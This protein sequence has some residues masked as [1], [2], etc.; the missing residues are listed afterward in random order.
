[1][2][3][4][5]GHLQVGFLFPN[6]KIAKLLHEKKCFYIA[7]KSGVTP[8]HLAAANGHLDLVKFF[9]EEVNEVDIN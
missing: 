8:L 5:Y 3:A 4:W 6:P 9:V 7:D 2:A 1:M